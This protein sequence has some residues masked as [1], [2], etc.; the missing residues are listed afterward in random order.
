VERRFGDEDLYIAR[1]DDRHKK[2]ALWRVRRGRDSGK[3]RGSTM[4]VSPARGEL[5]SPE[6]HGLA[7]VCFPP[8][9]A[10]TLATEM[11]PPDD[12]AQL[13]RENED[14]GSEEALSLLPSVQ[15]VATVYPQAAY[16]LI[17]DPDTLAQALAAV[18][19]CTVV[20]IDTETTGLDPLTDRLRL[21][22][23]AAPGWP[24]LVIDLWQIPQSAWEPLHAFLTLPSTVK[25]FHNAKFD[26]KFLRQAGLQV[27]GPLIDTMLASQLLD[28]GLWSRRHGL[29]DVVRH[30]LHAE[31]DKELQSSD[32]SGYLTPEQL[33]YAATDASVLTNGVSIL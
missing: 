22:Q 19:H 20:G 26:L 25:I 21:L 6:S 28:A 9:P 1:G 5:L 12:D 23:L 11:P 15:S 29:A 17:R 13:S 2:V 31:L 8:N 18:R 10:P 16:R 32:W 30:F 7:P 4:P 27:H 3:A 33:Q 24:V 14:H